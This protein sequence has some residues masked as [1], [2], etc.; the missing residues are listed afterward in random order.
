MD[1]KRMN[2]L[3]HVWILVNALL[4]ILPLHFMGFNMSSCYFYCLLGGIVNGVATLGANHGR[5][6]ISI[7]NWRQ[8]MNDAKLWL[9]RLNGPEMHF[10]FFCMVWVAA[11]PNFIVLLI[12]A[13]RSLWSICTYASKTMPNSPLFS[14]FRPVWT[15]LQSRERRSWSSSP[16][17]RSFLASLPSC[18]SSVAGCV[19]P[20]LPTCTGPS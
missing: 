1:A 17:W 13:R 20:S 4:W 19:R 8:G 3:G 5:P 12:L 16:C 6:P 18:R 14:A 9:Q 10:L 11:V 15:S 2:F 7:S